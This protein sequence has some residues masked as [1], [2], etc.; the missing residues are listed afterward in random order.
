MATVFRSMHGEVA[1]PQIFETDP[2]EWWR[3]LVNVS[4]GEGHGVKVGIIAGGYEGEQVEII[5]P[6]PPKSADGVSWKSVSTGAQASWRSVTTLAR[7]TTVNKV[8]TTH[9]T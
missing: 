8:T 3:G 9:W 7:T 4:A 5:G 2:V 6:L 1:A